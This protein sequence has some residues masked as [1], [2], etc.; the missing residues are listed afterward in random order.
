VV[1]A[2]LGV[3]A[4]FLGAGLLAPLLVLSTQLADL[5]GAGAVTDAQLVEA[6]SAP[7]NFWKILL[8]AEMC[9]RLV[10]LRTCVLVPRSPL[11]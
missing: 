1:G 4:C 8:T 3:E 10:G 6:L 5:G 11:R 9:V 2:L 7:D